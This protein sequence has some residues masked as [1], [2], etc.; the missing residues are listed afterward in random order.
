MTD[1]KIQKE[2]VTAYKCGS[3]AQPIMDELNERFKYFTKIDDRCWLIQK[4]KDSYCQAFWVN[5]TQSGCIVMSGDY[6]GIMLRPYGNANCLPNWVAGAT[7]LSYFAEKVYMG[8]RN[9]ECKEYSKEL[10]REN[11]Q[12]IRKQLEENNPEKVR[13][14]DD[15]MTYQTF[16][17]E[18][19]Y[20]YIIRELMDLLRDWDICEFSPNEYTDRIKWQHKCLVFWG[21][22]VLEGAF[23]GGKL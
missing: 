17:Q 8:N 2:E 19:E 15:F 1:D 4:N 12:Q 10:A 7:T 23:E 14:F 18:W 3:Y 20:Y 6:G 11:F 5:T 22:K 13:T 21:N 16:E 9:Q